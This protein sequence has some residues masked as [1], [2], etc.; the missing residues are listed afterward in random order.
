M[1]KTGKPK[2]PDELIVDVAE[3]ARRIETHYG[4]PQDIEWSFAG[5]DLY[6]LQSRDIVVKTGDRLDYSGIE[7]WNKSRNRMRDIIWT[8]AWSDEVLTRAITPLFYSV[9][10]ELITTTYDFMYRCYGLKELLPLKVMRFHKN[11]GYFSTRYLMKCLAYAPGFLRSED[12]LKFFTPARSRRP[13]EAPFF[14]G[15]N[16]GA[17]SA[18]FFYRQIFLYPLSQNLL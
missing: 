11:R 15:K 16:C 6:I 14:C 8:R 4:R 9:Q 3:T 7:R 12:M 17:S 2:I 10:A 5:E 18:P 1:S 13:G